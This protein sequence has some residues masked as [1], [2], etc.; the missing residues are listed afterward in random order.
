[1]PK[2]FRVLVVDDE[3]LIC[4]NIARSIEKAST[5]FEVVS[6][7]GDGLEALELARNLLPDVVFSDIKMPEMDGIALIRQLHQEMPS[8]KT[9]MVSGYDDFELARSALRNHAIDY[10]LKPVNP[11]DLK[12]TLQ[13]LENDLLA[14]QK[15][16]LPRREDSPAE[17]AERI[18]AYLRHNYA[19]TIDLTQLAQNYNFS[20]AYLSKIFKEHAGVSPV[21]YLT[22]YRMS[23]AKKLLQGSTLPV[24][25]V[26]IKVGYPDP[27]HFSKSFKNATGVTP[28]TYR[29]QFSE[30]GG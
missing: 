22:D 15:A 18:M 8:I 9:V 26:A 17:I 12:R 20:S 3:K 19:E 23:I 1:M 29:R 24:K 6:L 4:K 16:L 10:L 28:I 30:C 21:R 25:D 13:K 5:A 14:E 2:T 27:V 11:E 7:A